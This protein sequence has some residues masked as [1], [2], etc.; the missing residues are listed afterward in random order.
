MTS[1]TVWLK[2]GWLA[3]ARVSYRVG[4][5]MKL[6]WRIRFALID[7]IVPEK[8]RWALGQWYGFKVPIQS[9]GKIATK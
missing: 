4:A 5:K 9:S 7:L 1:R 6:I 3:L 2:N 8:D